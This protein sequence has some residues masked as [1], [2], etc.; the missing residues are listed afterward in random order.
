MK[1]KI[2]YDNEAV[3]GFKSGWGFSCFVETRNKN[4]LFDTGW[5]ANVLLYN[6]NKMDIKK[7]DIDIIIISHTHWDHM[8]GLA[9]ILHPGMEV[10]VPSSFSKRL[11]HE[12]SARATLHEISDGREIAEG[13]YTTGELGNDI[14][15]QAIALDTKDGILVMTGCAH[16]GLDNLMAAAGTFGNVYGAIGGFHDFD[17]L[18]YLKNLSLIGPCHCTARIMEIRKMFPE[19][20]ITCGAGQEIQLP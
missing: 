1:L 10:Y 2:L 14:K 9:Q 13:I 17:K 5:D 15:E 6:M 8:G 4:I 19:K 12:I 11:K 7:E 20:V 18:E 16:P 3:K